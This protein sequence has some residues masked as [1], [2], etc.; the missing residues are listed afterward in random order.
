MTPYPSSV[1]KEMKKFFDSLSEK[2]KRRYAAIETLKLSHG[3]RNYISQ[4][5]GCNRKTIRRGIQE[6]K[7]LPENISYTERIRVPGAGRKQYDNIPCID[8]KF[9]DV[10]RENTAGN[11]MDEKVLWTNLTQQEISEKLAEKYQICVSTQIV[12]KLLIKHNYRR[13]KAQKKQTMKATKNRNEQF[14]NIARIKSEYET[15]GNPII[16]MD[17]KKKRTLATIIGMVTCILKK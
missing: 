16:S 11:P 4:I 5:L 7:D 15:S 14:E 1:E 3:G 9:L 13:R 10:L 8:E 2:D 12:R 6:L 17:T